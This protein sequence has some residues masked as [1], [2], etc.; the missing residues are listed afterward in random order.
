MSPRQN[1]TLSILCY[2]EWAETNEPN[3]HLRDDYRISWI[4]V[5]RASRGESIPHV[6]ATYA[7]LGAHP[8]KVWASILARRRALLGRAYESFWGPVQLSFE[9][10]S[11][12]GS[13][14]PKKPAQSVH[15]SGF[16]GGQVVSL[17][18][19]PAKPGTAA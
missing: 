3:P 17:P 4:T 10:D 2:L 11:Q 6:T 16:A 8:E 18:R 12:R 15:E 7:V 19:P 1:K 14:P 9:W 13:L 5:L